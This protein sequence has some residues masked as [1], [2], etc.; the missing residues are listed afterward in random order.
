MSAEARLRELGLSL[1]PP[2]RPA[3]NYVEAAPAGNLLFLA[4]HGPR[5]ADGSLFTGRVGEDL[6]VEQGYEAA[7]AAALGLL[8]TMK[9]ELGDLDRVIRIVKVLGMVQCTPEFGQHPA[10]INGASD[11]L[12]AVLGKAGRH[13]RSAVGMTSLPFGIAVEVELVAEV[14]PSPV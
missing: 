2:A 5:H 6:T 4:G 10:V 7:R 9:A 12:V 8:S 3:G 13:A 1:P 14:A 11:L